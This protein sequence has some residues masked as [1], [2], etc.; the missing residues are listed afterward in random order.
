MKKQRTALCRACG[1]KFEIQS[2][3]E[4]CRTFCSNE[5]YMLPRFPIVYRFVCPDGR[6]YVGAVADGRKRQKYGIARSNSWLKAAFEIYPPETFTFELLE[7]LPY[8]SSEEKLRA[9][10]QYHINRLR[11]WLPE[12]GF[13]ITPAVWRGNGL[14]Q[15]AGRARLRER[16]LKVHDRARERRDFV[17]AQAAAAKQVPA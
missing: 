8:G 5:C 12:F 13:N 1:D 17:L 6:S 7:Q 3:G 10:E 11:S 2:Y 15:Q 9:R 14:A 4:G 16:I